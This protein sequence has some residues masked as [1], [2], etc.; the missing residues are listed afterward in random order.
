M[1]SS[2]AKLLLETGHWD[3]ARRIADSLLNNEDQI[4]L[5]KIQAL[6]VAASIKMRC[7]D[8]EALSM[9]N[10]AKTKAFQAMEMQRVIPVVVA[11]L[12]YEWITGTSLIE[13]SELTS[14]LSR[15][16]QVANAYENSELAFWLLKTRK[17][18]WRTKI[19]LDGYN[20]RNAKVA[21][22]AASVWQKSRCV[23]QQALTLFEGTDNNKR[24]A[25]SIIQ[26][27]AA[28]AVYQRM[29]FEMRAS[30]IKRIPRG[31]ITATQSNPALLT[32][33]ELDVLQL[34]K[35]GL[36]NKEIATKLFISAKTVD[37]HISAIF[38]KLDVNSRIKAV[39]EA[40][41]LEI[42]A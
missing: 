27:L 28:N 31:A 40:V 11:L 2:K 41:R 39:K 24:K 6:I 12:E 4:P 37:H 29:K 1:L 10:D 36:Q 20:I 38:F 7:G 26:G 19:L 3:E 35:E 21:V 34:L 13:K 32:R 33:R 42:I 5:V 9:L 22:K 16:E 25:I 30:G 23:Y 14:I 8:V 15:A 18:Q 17:Q